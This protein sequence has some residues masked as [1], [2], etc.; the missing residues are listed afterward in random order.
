MG[1]CSTKELSQLYWSQLE[2]VFLWAMET[3]RRHTIKK[4][5]Y[6]FSFIYIKYM[7][8]N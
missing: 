5:K 2:P 1:V 8:L 3:I 7:H 4:K 6:S